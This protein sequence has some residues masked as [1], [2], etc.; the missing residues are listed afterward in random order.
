MSA[1]LSTVPDDNAYVG[2]EALYAF[3]TLAP[4]AGGPE[5]RDLLA[6]AAPEFAAFVGASEPA[7]RVAALRVIG[8]V[9]ARQPSDPPAPNVIGDAVVI[10][11]NDQ[12]R[13]VRSAASATLGAMRYERAI[14]ALLE[15]FQHYRRGTV[16]EELLDALARI[17]HSAAKPSMVA[18]LENG[19]PPM[20]R[21]A[22][23]GLA[24]M[25]DATA[26]ATAE[27]ALSRDRNESLRLAR[28]FAAAR[29]GKGGLDEIVNAL[30]RTALRDQA[31]GYLIELA[32]GRAVAFGRHAQDPDAAIRR[33][34]A[35]A[36][37]VSGD[38]AARPIVDALA[39]DGD[40][41]VAQAAARAAA[42]L[43]AAAR[44]PS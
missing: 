20:K 25:N 34:V 42:R 10:A 44:R 9:Y 29:L 38:Q 6:N 4:N 7:Q 5:L 19:S 11:L 1:L 17:G 22:V 40:P 27:E 13:L 30:T 43:G 2:M 8:R 16:A 24:R 36:L 39:R 37:G 41:R 23:E 32:P 12:D 31:L 3:G 35:D 21:A 33:D 14:Q 28:A 18:A 15:L 26:L